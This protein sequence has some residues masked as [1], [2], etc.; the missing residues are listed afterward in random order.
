MKWLIKHDFHN[1]D[2]ESLKAVWIHNQ[3]VKNTITHQHYARILS[4]PEIATAS[5]YW[6]KYWNNLQKIPE[7]NIEEA[8]NEYCIDNV[9]KCKDMYD[10][11]GNEPWKNDQPCNCD[12]VAICRRGQTCT[13]G[14]CV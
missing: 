7:Y 2:Y 13:S 4:A 3:L 10:D 9:A 8:F 12:D 14:A 1:K 5:A 11:C 6:S